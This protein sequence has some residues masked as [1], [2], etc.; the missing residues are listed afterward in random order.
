MSSA[1]MDRMHS[2]V[3]L[4]EQEERVQDVLYQYGVTH[5]THAVFPVAGRSYVVDFFLSDYRTILECWQSGSRRGIA[6]TWME[7]NAA[8]IDWKFKRIKKA[9]PAL[10]CVAL[11]EVAQADPKKIREYV[12]PVMEHADEVCYSME[13]LG[14][15]LRELIRRDTG[16]DVRSAGGGG[17]GGGRT[18]QGVRRACDG[19]RGRSVLLHGGVGRG[20][21]GVMWAG[22]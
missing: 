18:G 16:D 10:N 12:G 19:A 7:K 5:L 20:G 14:R 22:S 3:P 21:E 17:A 13:E 6:L 4:T 9:S 15:V 1:W 11:A 2:L 8:Y